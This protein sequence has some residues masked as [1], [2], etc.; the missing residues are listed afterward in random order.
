[1]IV[2]SLKDRLR[3]RFNV[4]VAESGVQD[5]WEQAEISVVYL[6]PHNSFA[7]SLQERLDQLVVEDGRVL[8]ARVH[9][10]AL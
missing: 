8:I 1:M 10:E 7:D 3:S 5:R 6:A 2:R 9:R 4:S